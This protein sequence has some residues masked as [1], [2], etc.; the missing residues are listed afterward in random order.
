MHLPA[1]KHQRL[2]ENIFSRS[3]G[4]LFISLMVSFAMQKVISL[5]WPQLF[6]SA[7]ISFALGNGSKKILLLFMSECSACIFL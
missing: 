6:V 7:V 1:K 4:C 5:I 2:Q 3:V